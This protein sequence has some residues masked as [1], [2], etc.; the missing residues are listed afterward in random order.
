MKSIFNQTS[1]P[2]SVASS[3]Q[4]ETPTHTECSVAES[5][6]DQVETQKQDKD[7]EQ[8]NLK[9]LVSHGGE[10]HVFCFWNCWQQNRQKLGVSGDG[11]V[12][13]TWAKAAP[14]FLQF[15]P[16]RPKETPFC[17]LAAAS[18]MLFI[19]QFRLNALLHAQNEGEI[20]NASVL[21]TF[22]PKKQNIQRRGEKE[23]WERRL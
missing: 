8:K 3:T 2:V 20:R 10:L 21:W 13:Q 9:D 17:C 16:R 18:R 6:W 12:V 5:S 22:C 15:V 4:R 7:M 19:R 23:W 11:G 14:T 1:A